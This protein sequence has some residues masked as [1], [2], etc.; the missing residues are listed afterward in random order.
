MMALQDTII[1]VLHRIPWF[2][3]LTPEAVD[4]LA[5]IT[6]L[7]RLEPGEILFKEGDLENFLYVLYEGEVELFTHAPGYG[8]VRIIVAEPLDVIGWSVLTPVIRQ[9]TD[10]G[11]ALTASSLLCFNS[12]M[13]RQLC[14]EDHEF[15][16]AASPM[17]PPAAC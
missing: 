4:K 6:L 16:C 8:Q 14:E 10:T 11:R 13:L 7:R 17:S 12:E 15:L 1:H 9:R 5:R 2:N 3:E